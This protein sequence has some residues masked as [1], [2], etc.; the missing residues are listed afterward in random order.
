MD[1][2]E[3]LLSQQQLKH[4]PRLATIVTLFFFYAFSMIRGTSSWVAETQRTPHFVFI[5]VGTVCISLHPGQHTCV[6]L[7][8]AQCMRCQRVSRSWLQL[9]IFSAGQLGYGLCHYCGCCARQP[10]SASAWRGSRNVQSRLPTLTGCEHTV[11]LITVCLQ[12]SWAVGTPLLRLLYTLAIKRLVL[13]KFREGPR[14]KQWNLLR[15]FVLST[16][17][18]NPSFNGALGRTATA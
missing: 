16:L 5:K 15:G 11:Q 17:L 9:T 18:P 13:G 7:A 12:V 1:H 10:F 4:S 8:H 6:P 14:N 3:P 2:H